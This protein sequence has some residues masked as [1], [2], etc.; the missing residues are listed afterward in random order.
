MRILIA[1]AT[2]LIGKRLV[3]LCHEEGIRVHYLTTSK[4]KIQDLDNYKGFY[5]NPK[6]GIIEPKAFKNVTAVINLAGMSV[7]NR[8]TSSNRK[9][10]YNSRIDAANLIYETL[11][12]HSNQVTHY[13][14]ASAVGIY[15]PSHTAMYTEESTEVDTSF[16]GEVVQDW[17]AAAN[18]LKDLGARVAILRTGVVLDA[19]EGAFPKIIRPIKMGI[20]SPLG[21]GKQW[22]SWIH[23]EDVASIYIHCLKRGTQGV[24]NAV[25]PSPVTNAYMTKRVAECLNKELWAPKVPKFILKIVLGSMATLAVDGQLVH[26]NRL[27]EEGFRFRFVNVESAI[28]NLL[29]KKGDREEE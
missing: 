18:R 23:V 2:G 16:L 27:K 26:S 8:W 14:S 9:E 22:M 5:W 6:E 10:I 29:A 13:I 28:K 11:Q 17:E 24:V 19:N 20:G 3:K 4:S 21:S 12:N 25:A 15:P 7:S 1:G